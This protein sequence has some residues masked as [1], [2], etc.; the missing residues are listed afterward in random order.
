MP[1]KDKFEN[2]KNPL[3]DSDYPVYPGNYVTSLEIPELPDDTTGMDNEIVI[4]WAHR[5]GYDHA[6]RSA[7]AKLVQVGSVGTTHDWEMEA[8]IIGTRLREVLTTRH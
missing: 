8:E 6:F 2:E 3:Q 1:L 5:A 7:G 4:Q